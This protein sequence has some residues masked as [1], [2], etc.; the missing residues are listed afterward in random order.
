MGL[1]NYENQ[2]LMLYDI[3]TKKNK[4]IKREKRTEQILP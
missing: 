4:K 1:N 3:I 2:P